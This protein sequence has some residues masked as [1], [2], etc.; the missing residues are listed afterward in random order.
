MKPNTHKQYVALEDRLKM[1]VPFVSFDDAYLVVG[2]AKE[3]KLD[4]KDASILIES[5][6]IMASPAHYDVTER[7]QALQEFD[8]TISPY[9]PKV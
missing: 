1:V 9:R 6:G 2:L 7:S 5:V 3:N 8:K 4:I